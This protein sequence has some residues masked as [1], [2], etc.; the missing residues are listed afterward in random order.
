MVKDGQSARARRTVGNGAAW[1]ATA[2]N[3]T[4][5]VAARRSVVWAELGYVRPDFVT[6]ERSGVNN[7][8]SLPREAGFYRC[9]SDIELPA[10][11]AVG[12]TFWHAA[13]CA[14]LYYLAAIAFS[15]KFPHYR[16]HRPLSVREA[17]PW[18][19]SPWRKLCYRVSE[20][21]YQDLLCGTASKRFFL[22]PLQV[23]TDSQV[24][25][26]S[27][28]DS[29]AQ[30][31]EHVVASFA[32]HAE[33]EHL[34]VIKHHP[35]DRGYHS[36]AR[37]IGALA[38]RYAVGGRL[39]YLHDLHLPTLLDH[40]RGVVVINSTVGLSAMNH[41]VPL[42]VLGDAA[43]AMPELSFQ[44]RLDAFWSVS[45]TFQLDR[46]LYRRFRTYLIRSTQLNGNFFR[47]GIFEWEDLSQE[48]RATP[49]HPSHDAAKACTGSCSNLSAT[50]L[51]KR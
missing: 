35:M 38:V 2:D 51:T 3:A 20:R 9:L 49:Q 18:L 11:R 37:L 21:N 15:R 31:I 8:S 23:N 7:H 17:I 45:S 19:R 32:S 6:L 25:V 42:A 34:L 39:I 27:A 1:G 16:H 46:D 44:G 13:C 5:A 40:A 26:H 24:Q 30:F 41:G 48:E 29:V 10:E 36:Y 22:V 47:Y 28:F 33:S 4:F 50:S 12:N 43:Y 14:F